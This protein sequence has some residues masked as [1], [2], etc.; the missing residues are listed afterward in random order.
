MNMQR[1]FVVMHICPAI[2]MPAAFLPAK[3]AY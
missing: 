2:P 3:P 1:L